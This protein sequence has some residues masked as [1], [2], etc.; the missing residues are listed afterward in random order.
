[1]STS[2]LRP[3]WAK[4]ASHQG[5]RADRLA[6]EADI[7]CAPV[8]FTGCRTAPVGGWLNSSTTV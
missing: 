2:T 4:G 1:M 5:H 7:A 8:P 3:S 6:Q